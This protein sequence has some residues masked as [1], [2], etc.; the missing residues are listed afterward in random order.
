MITLFE[1]YSRKR[2]RWVYTIQCTY[3]FIYFQPI[4]IY[5]LQWRSKHNST[6]LP[7]NYKWQN[8][9]D[10][11][12]KTI[13]AQ[14]A[15]VRKV[16]ITNLRCGELSVHATEGQNSKEVDSGGGSL[17][18]TSSNSLIVFS[19]TVAPKFAQLSLEQFFAVA[20]FVM[21]LRHC[22]SILPT[23]QSE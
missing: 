14:S 1:L 17:H 15:L 5:F 7:Q 19:N 6:Y 12:G 4:S 8:G 20:S 16:L 9:K 10:C 22:D 18:P 23:S 11:K 3:T 21:S 2:T 13:Y